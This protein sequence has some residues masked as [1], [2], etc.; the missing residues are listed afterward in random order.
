MRARFIKQVGIRGRLRIYWDEVVCKELH[1]CGECP[2]GHPSVDYLNTCPSSYGKGSPGV[3]NAYTHIEDKLGETEFNVFGN[4][5]DYPAE[6]WAGAC[7]SCGATVPADAAAPR[8]V[9]E[10]GVRL[11]RQVFPSRLYDT[12]SG[13][14]E[15]GDVYRMEYHG[16]REH[17]ARLGLPPGLR[18]RVPRAVAR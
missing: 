1:E 17:S 11:V 3:H 13:A 2:V 10:K 15:P 6:R 18:V 16:N 5:E 7:E 4:V 8:A 12:A 14:P 9:G